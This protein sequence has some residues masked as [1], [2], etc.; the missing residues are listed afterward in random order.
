VAQGGGGLRERSVTANYV[1]I[2]PQALVVAIQYYADD[3]HAALRLA[4]LLADI[5]PQRRDDVIIAFARRFDCP[6]SGALSG[7]F[8]HVGKKFGV[9]NLPSIREATGHP[10]GCNGIWRST[11]EQ[12]SSS[13]YRGNLGACSVF[14][15]EPDGCPL[16]A[17]WA[18][19]I[20]AEH[21]RA[22]RAGKRVSGCLIEQPFPHVNGTLVAHLSMWRDRLSLHDT[23]P[24]QAWDLFHAAALMAECQ[25]T[26]LIKNVYGAQEWSSPALA[27]M[28]K[29][30]AWL[31][32]TKDASAI[33]WAERTLVGR[34]APALGRRIT[35]N[36]SP[37]KH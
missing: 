11:M 10:D 9:I 22:V 28:A 7:T 4:R 34:R 6:P 27:A 12:L 36:D 35:V 37:T 15:V 21:R 1:S 24:G 30:T 31:A 32:S 16:S 17:D 25:P 19:R 26:A 13:W 5:E 14:T 3:E 2:P 33:A 20:Q 18:D 8:L 29:E 23:P